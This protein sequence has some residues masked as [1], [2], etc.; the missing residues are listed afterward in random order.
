MSFN[1]APPALQVD[2]EILMERPKEEYFA[3]C[4]NLVLR[5]ARNEYDREGSRADKTRTE[6]VKAERGLG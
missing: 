4:G 3:R 5:R 2:V 1:L 6:L